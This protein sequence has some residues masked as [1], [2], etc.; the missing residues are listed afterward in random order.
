MKAKIKD[1]KVGQLF[2]TTESAYEHGVPALGST[3]TECGD[4]GPTMA[5]TYFCNVDGD[6]FPVSPDILEQEVWIND[7]LP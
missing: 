6:E 5:K 3:V 2:W 7:W 4:A 1:L